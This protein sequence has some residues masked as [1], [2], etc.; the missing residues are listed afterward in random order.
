[1][2]CRPEPSRAV[3]PVWRD[4]TSSFQAPTQ[5][6]VRIQQRVI[7]R[8]AP[9]QPTMPS[10]ML[11]ALPQGEI[12]P[13][14]EE[15]KF[16]KCVPVKG[17]AGVQVNGSNRLLLFLRDRRILSATLDKSCRARD[18]YSGFYIEPNEDGLLC[19]GRDQLHSRAGTNCNL[20][21]LRR[22]ILVGR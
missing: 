20:G 10:D 16:G 14:Y 3:A 8:I 21:K 15:R 4:L 22:L 12:T 18:F 9:R 19:S 17:I 11:S 1:M 13:H 6:Q 5:N 2:K 7:I